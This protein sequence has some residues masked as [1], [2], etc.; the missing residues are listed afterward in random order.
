MG[1]CVRGQGCARMQ[2]LVVCKRVL[3]YSVRLYLATV[4]KCMC[5]AKVIRPFASFSCLLHPV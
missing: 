2:A 3:A 5:I 1:W 4:N